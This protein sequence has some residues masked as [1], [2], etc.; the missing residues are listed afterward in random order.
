MRLPRK[1]VLAA[2]LCVSIPGVKAATGDKTEPFTIAISAPSAV[3]RAG[4]EVR[5]HAV[6]TNV[7][8]KEIL[9]RGS[10]EGSRA[11][12]NYTVL[13]HDRYGNAAPE[14]EYGRAARMHQFAGS[15]LK[16][17]LKPGE[18]MEED[19]FLSKQFDLSSPIDYVIQLSRPVSNDPK[20][21][22]VK[23]NEITITV[24]PNSDAEPKWPAVSGGRVAAGG[25][26]SDAPSQP[27]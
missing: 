6:L 26:G 1:V 13:V 15:V 14:T 21:G 3:V 24:V 19:T 23:S 10:H 11:E 4:D 20:D 25:P 2:A 18:K 27:Q 8:D 16:V 7:S 5:I 12:V 22:V 9:A 17:L